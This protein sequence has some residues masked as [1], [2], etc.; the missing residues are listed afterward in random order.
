M[1]RER[2]SGAGSGTSLGEEAGDSRHSRLRCVL[3][4]SPGNTHDP[5]AALIEEAIAFG[6][7]GTGSGIVVVLAPVGFNDESLSWPE[8]I[9]LEDLAAD[10]QVLIAQWGGKAAASQQRQQLCLHAAAQTGDG[11]VTPPILEDEAKKRAATATR[12]GEDRIDSGDVKDAE[13]RCLLNR[14]AQRH[15]PDDAGY[16][17]DGAGW[18]CAGDGVMDMRVAGERRWGVAATDAGDPAARLDGGDDVNKVGLA[19]P[20]AEQRSRGAVGDNASLA[21]GKHRG[22][23]QTVSLHPG[24]ADRKGPTE[25]RVQSAGGNGMVD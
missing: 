15:L 19:L 3:Q 4:I 9:D 21:A 2:N 22:E 18:A 10:P 16:V 25:D 23:H 1:E 14:S 8:K 11:R 5:E 17:D 13:D 6:I 20:E 12:A 7:A 24:V